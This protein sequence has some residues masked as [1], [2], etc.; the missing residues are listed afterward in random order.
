MLYKKNIILCGIALVFLYFITSNFYLPEGAEAAVKG[1]CANCHTMHNSEDGSDMVLPRGDESDPA[2]SGG[3]CSGCHNTP[4]E[5]LL[6]RSCIAC[7]AMSLNGGSAIR[8]LGGYPVPQ[9]VYNASESLAAGNFLNVFA[10]EGGDFYGHNVHGFGEYIE[11]DTHHGAFYPMPPGYY[12]DMDYGDPK[13]FMWPWVETQ[14]GEVLCAGAFGC[15]GNRDEVSQTQAMAGSHHADD[16]ALKFGS[17]DTSSQGTGPN[18]GTSYRFLKG[19][20]GGED[21]DWENNASSSAHNEYMGADNSGTT[22][23]SQ[24]AG[25]ISTMSQFC[26]GCH[27]NFHMTGGATGEGIDDANAWIR[28]PTD[29]KIPNTAP[30][31][32]YSTY[33]ISVPVA[34]STIPDPASSTTEID[35]GGTAIVFCLSC[36]RAHASDQYDSL[37]FSYNADIK[38]GGGSSSSEGCFA[39]HG[40]K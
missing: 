8:N 37:R 3:N 22:R 40:D 17:I 32:N 5:N 4:R 12:P 19:V 21:S 25:D 33:N 39:C 6:T 38:T 27:G 36:H 20:Q 1:Q 13:Y 28:H 18:S 14:P 30:Y 10:S 9:V 2:G 35:T 7:H 15:H 23:T 34:R 26:A 16:S 29:I 11:R 31:N 24:G